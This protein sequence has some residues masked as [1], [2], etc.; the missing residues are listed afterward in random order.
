[1]PV[2]S[3]HFWLWFTKFLE[4][5]IFYQPNVFILEAF[6]STE[7]PAGEFYFPSKLYILHFNNYAVAGTKIQP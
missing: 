7:L 4:L 6:V 3:L 1:M 5:V 2:P